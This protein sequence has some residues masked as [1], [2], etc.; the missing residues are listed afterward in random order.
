VYIATGA[1]T[2]T[3]VVASAKSRTNRDL[4]TVDCDEDKIREN[5][6]RYLIKRQM[7]TIEYVTAMLH[8]TIGHMKTR[9]T[10]CQLL[11]ND[12]TQPVMVKM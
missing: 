12:G 2:M 8:I 5:S 11:S 9:T 3:R 1:K 4:L 6:R 7:E 10:L